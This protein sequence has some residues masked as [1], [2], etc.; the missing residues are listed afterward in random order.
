MSNDVHPKVKNTAPVFALDGTVYVGGC[1]VVSN[2]EDPDGSVHYVLALADGTRTPTEIHTAMAARFP[3]LT[4]EE[5]EEALSAFDAYGFLEDGARTSD[6]VLDDYSLRRWDRNLW[7]FEA[8]AA[9]ANDK[10]SMQRRLQD[11][12]IALLGVGGLGSHLLY[13]LAAAGVQDIRIV[14]FDTIDL[15]NLN[16]QI[17]YNEADIGLPKTEVAQRRIKAF[18]PRMKVEAVQTRIGSGEDVRR[19]VEDRDLVIAVVDRPTMSIANWVNAGC[20]AAG[21][22]FLAGGV[23]TKRAIYYGV[24]PGETGCVECWRRH[25]AETDPVSAALLDEKRRLGFEGDNAAF[26]PL[27]TV[28]TGCILAEVVRIATGI[29]PPVASGRLMELTFDD[30]SICEAE[31]W[32]RQ[33]DCPVCASAATPPSGSVG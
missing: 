24:V 14:D 17:I 18:S 19:L 13:D 21:V 31:T 4:R 9:L 25:V 6:G 15:S 3:H 2:I 27:V 22:R 30:F 10:Y 1:G 26:G 12:R 5:I 16:R 28:L 23:E 8:Y 32:S 29:S 7:F 20:V 11:I 33:P